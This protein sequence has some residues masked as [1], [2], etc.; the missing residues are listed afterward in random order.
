MTD[1]LHT[2]RAEF[3]KLRAELAG[4]RLTREDMCKR[5]GVES[6]TLTRMVRQGRVPAP[7]DGKWLLRDVLE[8]ESQP[9]GDRRRTRVVVDQRESRVTP[10]EDFA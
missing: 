5:L 2:L 8:W 6:H 4:T 7:R 10:P 1:L 9:A 3:D